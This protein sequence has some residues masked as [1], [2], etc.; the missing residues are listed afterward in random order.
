[1]YGLSNAPQSWLFT[2]RVRGATKILGPIF[3]ALKDEYGGPYGGG[4][5]PRVVV[6]AGYVDGHVE[7]FGGEELMA[8]RLTTPGSG[9]LF[10]YVPEKIR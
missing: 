8:E 2:H 9:S 7:R 1:M 6:N 10:I 4:R 3:Y 5:I